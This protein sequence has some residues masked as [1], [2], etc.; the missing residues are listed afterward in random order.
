MANCLV[1]TF[2]DDLD[3]SSVADETV[4]FAIDGQRYEI[5]LSAAHAA[6]LRSSLNIYIGA[7]RKVPVF[8]LKV[9]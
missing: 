9:G 2:V 7:A 8:R 6:E 1:T 4:H 3:G 5:D